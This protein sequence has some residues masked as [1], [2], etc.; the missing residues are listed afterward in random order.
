MRRGSFLLLA[1]ASVLLTQAAFAQPIR[2]PAFPMDTPMRM[3]AI[4]AVCT[5]VGEDARSDPRW[6]HYSLRVEVVGAKGEYLGE[7]QVTI[8]KNDEALASVNC[9]G[10]WVLFTLAPGVYSVT[11]ESAGISR[12]SKAN[13]NPNGQVRVV[14]RF[15]SEQ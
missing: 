12:T 9:A 3:R 8:S 10:P 4:E 14:L 2:S 7:A 5:G 1:V 6:S 13:V 11:A 15:P